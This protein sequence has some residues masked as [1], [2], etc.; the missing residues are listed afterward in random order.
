[1]AES[2]LTL[3]SLDSSFSKRHRQ[4]QG[5]VVLMVASHSKELKPKL[6]QSLK[7]KTTFF[8]KG[9]HNSYMSCFK[10]CCNRR[11]LPWGLLAWNSW[12]RCWSAWRWSLYPWMWNSAVRRGERISSHL[13]NTIVHSCFFSPRH[14][15]GYNH[16]SF[17][18]N[19]CADSGTKVLNL[20]VETPWSVSSA[21][22]TLPDAGKKYQK[23]PWKMLYLWALNEIRPWFKLTS[24]GSEIKHFFVALIKRLNSSLLIE[25]ERHKTGRELEKQTCGS[26]A[27]GPQLIYK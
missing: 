14:Y 27:P 4:I 24:D 26:V 22:R 25:W 5:N 20:S 2:V 1:M 15:H 21:T 7:R 6:I 11:T 19:V 18:C 12:C 8:S 9:Y 3:K 13:I 16:D 23:W 17:S 10:C